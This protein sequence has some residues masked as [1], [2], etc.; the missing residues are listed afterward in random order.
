MFTGLVRVITKVI[1]KFLEVSVYIYWCSWMYSLVY[2]EKYGVLL[3]F[4][5]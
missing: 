2:Q 5:K 3:M 1:F 4:S